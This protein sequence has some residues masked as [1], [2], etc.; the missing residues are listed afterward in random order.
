M[1]YSF[2]NTAGR[3]RARFC[4]NHS[5]NTDSAF[6]CCTVVI[7]FRPT[8]SHIHCSSAVCLIKVDTEVPS[9]WSFSSTRNVLSRILLAHDASSWIHRSLCFLLIFYLVAM[10]VTLITWQDE[11]CTRT[12]WSER[13]LYVNSAHRVCHVNWNYSKT[14]PFKPMPCHTVFYTYA[15]MCFLRAMYV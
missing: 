6:R 8:C 3:Y 4:Q 5:I 9:S 14:V 2:T 10:M 1:T 11:S 7:F 13:K 12:M 15:M